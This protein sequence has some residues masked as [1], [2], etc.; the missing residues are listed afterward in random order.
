MKTDRFSVGVAGVYMKMKH[1]SGYEL[2]PAGLSMIGI[3]IER[4]HIPVHQTLFMSESISLLVLGV[5]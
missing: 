5:L 2:A 3:G 1:S 4:I